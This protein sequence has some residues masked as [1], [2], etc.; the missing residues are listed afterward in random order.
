[1][2]VLLMKTDM[3]PAFGRMRVFSDNDSAGNVRY[4]F[5]K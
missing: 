3:N 4:I 5:V 2:S 1:M